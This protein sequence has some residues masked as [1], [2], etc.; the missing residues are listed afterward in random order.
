[1]QIGRGEKTINVGTGDQEE[2]RTGKAEADGQRREGEEGWGAGGERRGRGGW[3]R[4]KWR[5]RWN[6]TR[7]SSGADLLLAPAMLSAFV[8]QFGG[9]VGG[10]VMEEA[11]RESG[12]E[13]GMRERRRD[14]AA[15]LVDAKGFSRAVI[16]DGEAKVV[17]QWGDRGR[18]RT[19][20][21]VWRDSGC[22]NNWAMGYFGESARS[23][24]MKETATGESDNV[25]VDRA[26]EVLRREAE[27]LDRCE[28]C[29]VYH[30]LAGGTGCWR[31]SVTGGSALYF[32]SPSCRSLLES[33]PSRSLPRDDIMP[34]S[35]MSSLP[36][37]CAVCGI[38]GLCLRLLV[39][40][41]RVAVLQQHALSFPHIGRDGRMSDVLQ[42]RTSFHHVK[43]TGKEN[44]SRPHSGA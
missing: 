23:V 21:R 32:P 5:R 42:R 38:K 24:G 2:R 6:I 9:S 11:T 26:M 36:H 16:V 44:R 13:E 22:G 27:R 37:I 33:F 34:G 15:K 39:T 12:K 40:D 19:E 35:S 31:R 41:L 18:L 28:G 30:S 20:N 7:A 10:M 25:L 3:K 1:M 4:R 29:M 14:D 43:T 17:K 8:G